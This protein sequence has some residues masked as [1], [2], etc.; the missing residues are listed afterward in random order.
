[1]FYPDVLPLFRNLQGMKQI[2]REHSTAMKIS[3]GVVTNS[4]DRVPS[5]L[6]SLGLRVGSLRHEI[7][8]HGA[9][10]ASNSVQLSDIDFVILSYDVGFE[11]PSRRIFDAAK[12]LGRLGDVPSDLWR[13]VHVGDDLDKDLEGAIQAGWEGLLLDREGS[14]APWKPGMAK[15]SMSSLVG[16]IH[17]IQQDRRSSVPVNQA[18][19]Y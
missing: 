16:L 4:D 17:R 19:G 2:A 13:Y 11:K 3:V 12:D 7:G 8:P 18:P 9:D 15:V 14:H 5:V 1:M 10:H 6:S